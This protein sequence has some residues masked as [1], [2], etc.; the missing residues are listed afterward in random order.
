MIRR[1]LRRRALLREA[2]D[3]ERRA[4]AARAEQKE[5][6][7]LAGVISLASMGRVGGDEAAMLALAAAGH[8]PPESVGMRGPSRGELLHREARALEDRA[9]ALRAELQR[10]GP[11][12]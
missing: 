5:L 9:Q 4:A 2:L 7:R 6:S 10:K 1:W 12:R 3:L 8:I 11:L